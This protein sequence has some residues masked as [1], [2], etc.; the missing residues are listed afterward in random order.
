[1]EIKLYTVSD[2]PRT[3]EKTLG[4]ADTRTGAIRGEL[5]V[6]RP[7]VTV[8]GD[9]TGKNYAYI[10]ALGRY[11]YI[12][13]RE[14]IRTGLTALHLRCDVLMSW[15]DSIKQCPAVFER[16]ENLV[17]AY[18]ADGIVKVQ[19]YMQVCTIPFDF[20]FVYGDGTGKPEYI[21]ILAG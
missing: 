6:I 13:D 15:A 8:E 11:Y 2:D 3:L 10:A 19:S 21:V 7:T 14:I 1:M 9:I 5:D 4:T 16:S 20:E 17:N 18:V 12:E